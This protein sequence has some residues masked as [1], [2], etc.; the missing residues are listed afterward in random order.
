MKRRVWITA[1]V[2]LFFNAASGLLGGYALI[3][4]PSGGSMQM[5]LSF[6]EHSCF[7]DFLFPGIILFIMIGLLSL[8]IALLTLYRVK[9]YPWLILFQACVLLGWLSIEILIIKEFYA[10]LHVPY[11]LVGVGLILAGITLKKK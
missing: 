11:Y 9:Y 7:E 8:C 5:P 6:L 10:P 3:S 2:L 1:L 4:D